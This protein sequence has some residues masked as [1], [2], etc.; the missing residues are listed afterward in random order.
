MGFTERR[1][2]TH[3][4]WYWGIVGR[5][6]QGCKV[7][8]SLKGIRMCGEIR[9]S[10][11]GDGNNR[12]KSFENRYR[13]LKD[14]GVGYQGIRDGRK[15][16]QRSVVIRNVKV[17]ETHRFSVLEGWLILSS[18]LPLGYFPYW[19]PYPSVLP[20]CDRS[21]CGAVC[22]QCSVRK[23]R[24][25]MMIGRDVLVEGWGKLYVEIFA[26]ITDCR[27]VRVGLIH[28]ELVVS[29]VKGSL[30]SSIVSKESLQKIV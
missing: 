7:V 25:N 17:E 28:Q 3:V 1:V 16:L 11:A 18:L 8:W 30:E 22:W 4:D 26:G 10:V 2:E 20:C 29:I 15:E 6:S 19:S 5:W 12:K 13:S 21:N 24:G 14:W 27:D 9:L 23:V